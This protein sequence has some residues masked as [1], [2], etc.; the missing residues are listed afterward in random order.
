[1]KHTL[2]E[3]KANNNRDIVHLTTLDKLWCRCARQPYPAMKKPGNW[4][5]TEMVSIPK[6]PLHR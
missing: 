2:S 6:T 5:C 1:M 4:P 3:V